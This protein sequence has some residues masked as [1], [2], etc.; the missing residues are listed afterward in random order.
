MSFLSVLPDTW[1]ENLLTF[2]QRCHCDATPSQDSE[3]VFTEPRPLD[4]GGS[5]TDRRVPDSPFMAPCYPCQSEPELICDTGCLWTGRVSPR[6]PGSVKVHEVNAGEA[7]AA[8]SRRR[9]AAGAS[10]DLA[11]DG[12]GGDTILYWQP[13]GMSVSPHALQLLQPAARLTSADSEDVIHARIAGAGVATAVPVDELT[14]R[15]APS[16][17]AP[18]PPPAPVL[19]SDA[20]VG[21]R[22][23]GII[24]TAARVAADEPEQPDGTAYPRK[25]EGYAQLN[26]TSSPHGDGERQGEVVADT[27]DTALP[28]PVEHEEDREI[29]VEDPAGERATEAD[30][31]SILPAAEEAKTDDHQGVSLPAEI[32]AA[33]ADAESLEP[34]AEPSAPDETVNVSPADSAIPERAD[35][36]ASPSSV[37]TK[38]AAPAGSTAGA[39]E[40]LEREASS[41]VEP[42]SPKSDVRIDDDIWEAFRRRTA[43]ADLATS[44][45]AA[46]AAEA[47]AAAALAQAEM[48]VALAALA[49]AES[50]T[51]ATPEGD[52]AT[53]VGG[54]EDQKKTGAD[55]AA[56]SCEALIKFDVEQ[57]GLDLLSTADLSTSSAIINDSTLS[58]TGTKADASTVDCGASGAVIDDSAL[59]SIDTKGDECSHLISPD[60]EDSLAGKTVVEQALP[61]GDALAAEH[62]DSKDAQA[63]E[64]ERHQE[65]QK[66]EQ[67]QEQQQ[68]QNEQQNEQQPEHELLVTPREAP[69]FEEDAGVPVTKAAVPPPTGTLKTRPSLR[70]STSILAKVRHFEAA[71]KAQE[72]EPLSPPIRSLKSSA[73]AERLRTRFGGV[74]D[75]LDSPSRPLRKLINVTEQKV[76]K[77]GVLNLHERLAVGEGISDVPNDTPGSKAKMLGAP[78]LRRLISGDVELKQSMEHDVSK[79]QCDVRHLSPEQLLKIRT[80]TLDLATESQSHSARNSFMTTVDR[81]L[82]EK[83]TRRFL[84]EQDL[85]GDVKPETLHSLGVRLTVVIG[86]TVLIREGWGIVPARDDLPPLPALWVVQL[87]EDEWPD[88]RGW[89]LFDVEELRLQTLPG[90]Q[91]DF[92][93]AAGESNVAAVRDRTSGVG[94]D[95]VISWEIAVFD[96]RRDDVLAELS[97]LEGPVS[98]QNR[99]L[100]KELSA[101]LA[102]RSTFSLSG[103]P[104]EQQSEQDG[105]NKLQKPAGGLAAMASLAAQAASLSAAAGAHC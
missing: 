2:A 80:P 42:K 21:K 98:P 71:A 18:P 49:E 70:K 19:P 100:N 34:L 57:R 72:P 90:E 88:H 1:R 54:G 103:P 76:L 97:N 63:G 75:T 68:Q 62:L 82:F 17:A 102:K 15:L 79:A 26:S 61:V 105:P 89:S 40:K 38:E 11:Q 41:V 64:Q 27:D 77:A 39:P 25:S 69:A 10:A 4:Y 24:S 35:E 33:L 93:S 60:D 87:A 51:P 9:S 28:Q 45:A 96:P 30:E 47:E 66:Q 86:A 101:A 7:E 13:V 95:R 65:Q 83:L 58:S 37:Q 55:I 36:A 84:G 46:A 5:L 23:G 81:H 50:A 16:W 43:S 99:S 22:L 48:A 3:V 59:S 67:Q 32:P 29:F 53:A 44:D 12:H 20:L 94:K 8:G 31:D 6:P 73:V 104:D 14:A 74:T 85:G 52:A 78:F 92:A 91:P 56:P